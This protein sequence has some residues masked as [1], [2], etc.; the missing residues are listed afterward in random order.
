MRTLE[1]YIVSQI[2][3]FIGT[4]LFVNAGAQIANLNSLEEI[5]TLKVIL[6][7]TLLGLF[8]ILIKFIY[9]KFKNDRQD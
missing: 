5:L 2:G 1:F 4:A 3:M 9:K 6:S 8:P 7:L